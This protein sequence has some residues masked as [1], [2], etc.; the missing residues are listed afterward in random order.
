MKEGLELGGWSLER[1]CRVVGGT[2]WVGGVSVVWVEKRRRSPAM[3]TEGGGRVMTTEGR[4]EVQLERE[5]QG[6]ERGGGSAR[7]FIGPG[8]GGH[9]ETRCRHLNRAL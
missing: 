5:M 8:A 2:R 7:T 1:V 3:M 9:P 6:R 4:V